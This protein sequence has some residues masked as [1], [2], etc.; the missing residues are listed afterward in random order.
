MSTYD[1]ALDAT[2]P[3]A[4]ISSQDLLYS[5]PLR[6]Y[7]TTRGCL[8]AVNEVMTDTAHYQ[9]ICGDR[10]YVRG[11]LGKMPARGEKILILCWSEIEKNLIL[12]ANCKWVSVSGQ[13]LTDADLQAIF[14]FF[15]TG[16]ED[17]YCLDKPGRGFSAVS[18]SS[19]HSAIPAESDTSLPQ[20][21]TLVRGAQEDDRLRIKRLLDQEFVEVSKTP[22]YK[23]NRAAGKWW[24]FVVGIISLLPVWFL[25]CWLVMGIGIRIVFSS[26]GSV[27]SGG[28]NKNSLA[29]MNFGQQRLTE[30]LETARWIL[31]P[32]GL[33]GGLRGWERVVEVVRMSG[34]VLVT[35]SQLSL[36]GRELS[37]GIVGGYRGLDNKPPLSLAK[38]GSLQV[39]NRSLLAKTGLLVAEIPLAT[40]GFLPKT[41]AR[42]GEGFS[43]SLLNNLA[44]LRGQ[45]EFVDRFLSVYPR[46]AGFA[47]P[48][49]YLLL[50]QNSLELRPTGGFIGSIAE[51]GVADGQVGELV[52]RDVYEV[53]GQLKG[54]VDPP[55]PIRE[56]LGVEHWYLRDSNW[57]PDFG[58]SAAQAAWFYAK[59][60]GTRV[61]GVIGVS[62][63]LVVELLKISGPVELPDYNDRI[64]AD[65]F[66]GKALYYTKNNFFPGSTQKKDFL[67]VLTN[68]LL[69][70]LTS[71]GEKDPTLVV[72]ALKD[73]LTRR[74]LQFYFTDPEL[75]RLVRRFGWAG[76]LLE[77]P[78]CEPETS[79]ASL[80]LA[81]AEANL[82]VS[83]VN[84][85][86]KRTTDRSI[87][88]SPAGEVEE[89]TSLVFH[90]T[91]N[92]TQEQGGGAYR[93]YIRVF[94][95]KK[96][97]IEQVRI[98]GVLV[99]KRSAGTQLPVL[100]YWESIPGNDEE[101]HQEFGVALDVPAGSERRLSWAAN[102]GRLETLSATQ[103]KLLVWSPKQSGLMTETIRAT[104]RFPSFWTVT[105]PLGWT[106]NFLAKEVVLEYNTD[107]PQDL[108][109]IFTLK[110]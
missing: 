66:Y 42:R 81:I 6:R 67:A 62:V 108:F 105:P 34:Q 92:G 25:I 102:L 44:K 9:L 79:C 38:I 86:L 51:L 96:V 84:Y 29:V 77:L 57:D 61:D 4:H 30:F 23:K 43:E 19:P 33:D 26:L 98:D 76:H 5:E 58:R 56:L 13:T 1:Q 27:S 82:S 55:G 54:H 45:L 22:I 39:L 99:E 90:N 12:P 97:R 18:A 70:R 32:L 37:L 85:Y 24:I 48:Q 8:V 73:A 15:F 17:F 71:S 80:P 11:I 83:K 95:P 53:D 110:K 64:T 89:D 28:Y 78:A 104:L 107:L 93:S 3:L 2:L 36:E 100:P 50:F 20:G 40:V 7:L 101:W 63:P 91:S 31:K 16:S 69:T 47:K 106:Q 21:P 65:N 72:G 87:A 75:G 103:G 35:A 109:A 10:E 46:L 49:K 41:L 88:I 60:T 59:E 52:I 74:N 14:A 68:A 94:L